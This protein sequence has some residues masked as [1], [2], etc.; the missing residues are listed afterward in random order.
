[1][2]KIEKILADLRKVEVSDV[3]L[4]C[5]KCGE[6]C[7]QSVPFMEDELKKIKRKYSKR[8]KKINAI[9][10]TEDNGYRLK[11]KG[12]SVSNMNKC[13]FYENNRCSIYEDRP[14]LCRDYG[15]KLY[16]QCG[17]NGL[18]VIPESDEEKF[19]LTATAQK[20]SMEYLI[21]GVNKAM[22]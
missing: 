21:N 17:Y 9:K 10:D 11:F 8:F 19:N 18:T 4:P 13:V 15:S 1:M 6:C 12:Q 14:E 2:N 5:D 7:T 3:N 20:R 22:K 16:A